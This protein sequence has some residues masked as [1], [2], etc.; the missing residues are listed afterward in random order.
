MF[1][2]TSRYA[3]W[4]LAVLV[5]ALLA[6]FSVATPA[7]PERAEALGGAAVS[8]GGNHTCALTTG[9][10]VKCWGYNSKGQLG[11]GSTTNSNVPVD[12]SGL[13]SGV[14]AVSAGADHTCALTTGGGVKCWGSNV[15]GRL[16][17]GT[18]TDSNVPVDVSGL[19][20]GVAAVSAGGY[21]TCALTT[22]G[23]V[24]CW[25]NN[26]IGQLGDGS[27]TNSNVPVDVSGLTSGVAAVSAG[28]AHT[29]ALTT[30]GGVKCWGH[31]TWGQLGDGSTTDSSV[32]VDVSGLTSGVA[33]VGAGDRHTCALTT[34]GGV[35][36]WG[37][38]VLGQLGD[39]NGGV[40]PEICFLFDPCSTT[41]VD[42]SGLSSGV[43]AVS[44][45]DRHTC[46]LT[47]GGGVKCWGYNSWGQLGD[48]S[49]TDSSVPVD[50]SGLTS[51]VAAVSAGGYHTC[52]LTTG[53]GVKC[54][55]S[56]GFGELGDG[57]N[58]DSNVPVDVSGLFN[59]SGT[60]NLVLGGDI[61]ETCSASIVHA[62][63]SLSADLACN[64]FFFAS[65]TGTIDKLANT[66]SIDKGDLFI[67]GSTDGIGMLG[68][69]SYPDLGYSGVV[70]GTNKNAKDA[71]TQD[72]DGDGCTDLMEQQTSGG[73]ETTGGLRNFLNPYDFYDVLGPGAALPTDGVIDLPNDI[74]GVIL[75]FAP[76]G[77]APYDVQFDRGLSG[78][79]GSWVNTQPPD[80]VIDL[81]NDILGVILQFNHRCVKGSPEGEL[82][83]RCGIS[84]ALAQAALD[85]CT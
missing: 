84:R 38:N 69:W 4:A 21:H 85:N 49:T 58:T 9:G 45:G 24:K 16:G 67:S 77:A 32:P 3:K 75:H 15:F 43:A 37:N 27:N 61:V 60:W 63:S 68:T 82:G 79:G 23:G 36:C 76:T 13:S 59:A 57:T 22:G 48:G 73:S 51:G 12:V 1:T 83:E 28:G 72:T 20:S 31:N 25:G 56:N 18:N 52:A 71:A 2:N 70:G 66:F 30:G 6:A 33:A 41:P 35:K 80:G 5:G 29:C 11:D 39:G 46:A 19:T 10:G 64:I 26:D 81:P 34:G 17:D 50:V 44:A 65:L 47:T 55:G 74:L 54:W 8:A 40:G 78:P 62:G 7:G 42:V 53:G 14:A